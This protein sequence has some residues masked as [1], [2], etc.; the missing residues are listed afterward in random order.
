M[1]VR[2]CLSEFPNSLFD[3]ENFKKLATVKWL[4]RPCLSGHP[5]NAPNFGILN[6]F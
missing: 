4:V 3:K 2:P 1:L 6:V 5:E